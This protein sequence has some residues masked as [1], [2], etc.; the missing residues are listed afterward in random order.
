M[1]KQRDEAISDNEILT[2]R[3]EELEASCQEM[4][5]ELNELKENADKEAESKFAMI[6][7]LQDRL[8]SLKSE[9]MSLEGEKEN[10][11]TEVNGAVDAMDGERSELQAEIESYKQKLAAAV[12]DLEEEKSRSKELEQEMQT[13]NSKTSFTHFD[14]HLAELTSQKNTL[15]YE[16]GKLQSEVEQLQGELTSVKAN[17]RDVEKVQKNLKQAETKIRKLK[18]ELSNSRQALTQAEMMSQ[19]LQTTSEL[20]ETDFNSAIRA[21]DEALKDAKILASRVESLEEAIQQQEELKTEVEEKLRE[22]NSKVAESLENMMALHTELQ[23]KYE[24]VQIEL[25]KRDS[26][27]NELKKER[28][29]LQDKLVKVEGQFDSVSDKFSE[30]ESKQSCQTKNIEREIKSVKMDNS[31]LVRTL[32]DTLELNEQLRAQVSLLEETLCKQRAENDKLSSK[33]K[34]VESKMKQQESSYLTKIS[35]L[36]SQIGKERDK[37]YQRME[38][39]LR[40]VQMETENILERN[41][42]LLQQNSSLKT[43]VSGLSQKNETL[44]EKVDGL[45]Q[46]LSDVEQKLKQKAKQASKLKSTEDDANKLRQKTQELSAQCKSQEKTIHKFVTQFKEVQKEMKQLVTL[47]N[48]QTEVLTEKDRLLQ[49][50]ELKNEEL[51]SKFHESKKQISALQALQKAT[52]TRLMEANNDTQIATE[53]LEDT[54]RY[55]K[56]R[57]SALASE[58]STARRVQKDVEW[59]NLEQHHLLTQERMRVEDTAAK[60]RNMIKES[61]HHLMD[62][63]DKTEFDISLR[64]D[65]V[66]Q[67]SSTTMSPLRSTGISKAKPDVDLSIEDILSVSQQQN[68]TLRSSHLKDRHS[69][70]SASPF[71]SSSQKLDAIIN[72]MERRR[73]I[74]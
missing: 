8:A 49:A 11:L 10:I 39:Q 68:T 52:E 59:R 21:R 74:S 30:L 28:K 15:S 44:Q 29:R 41:S 40:T 70:T 47:H 37:A 17:H 7:G 18:Q 14:R 61:R 69:A 13:L 27:M 62:I 34:E 35:D 63:T 48:E 26:Q 57:F 64:D 31:K 72:E 24:T 46:E 60:A 54:N 36:E 32:Q 55:F 12:D 23:C 20:R 45:Q 38:D 50:E 16:N 25:G 33:S 71:T 3:V 51:R 42:S 56:E 67:L 9:L 5:K 58:L 19:Q 1:T 53:T 2:Q 22:D 65:A 66:K 6:G 73:L 43:E 4:E